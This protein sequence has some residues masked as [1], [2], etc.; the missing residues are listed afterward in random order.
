MKSLEQSDEMRSWVGKSARGSDA[1]RP[2]R[3]LLVDDHSL[4][5]HALKK[6]LS[7]QF[8]GV[9]LSEAADAL[10]AKKALGE[11]PFDVVILDV[12][13]PGQGG[14]HLLEFIR[15]S[16]PETRVLVVSG[17]PEEL[18]AVRALRAGASGCIS[19]GDPDCLHQVCRAVKI[20]STGGKFI[21]PTT[22]DLL[23]LE[24]GRDSSKPLHQTLS[25]REY[26]I[27]VR[28]GSG[29]APRDI[30]DELNISVKTVG[31]YRARIMF[32]MN[33]KSN[34]ELIEY[35][36]RNELIPKACRPAV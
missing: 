22:A 2:R 19:K 32:K 23:A 20:I 18:F 14:I 36:I 1:I 31:T 34:A 9:A 29:S 15:C 27:L 13:L 6:L 8:P 30:A 4:V 28:L 26:D 24:L 3:I 25:N 16:Y 17:Y 5:R 21:S 35:T 10:E 7:E 12:E 33:M 11:N